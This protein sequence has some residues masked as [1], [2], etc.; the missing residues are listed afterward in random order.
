VAE[1]I[2]HYNNSIR[3]Y[4][5]SHCRVSGATTIYD[6]LKEKWNHPGSI[7][8]PDSFMGV[9]IY[10]EMDDEGNVVYQKDNSFMIYNGRKYD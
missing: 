3:M 1:N 7:N 9:S 10:D 5:N 8:A 4:L 6:Y 2:K